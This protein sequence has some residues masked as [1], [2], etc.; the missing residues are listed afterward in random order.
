MRI[1]KINIIL[2][3]I[4]VFIIGL[5]GAY[6]GASML[7]SNNAEEKEVT[8]QNVE[9]MEKVEQAY[10]LIEQNYV[11][12][13]E[14]N[15]LIEGAIQGMLTTLDDPYSTYMDEEAMGNFNEQIESSFQGI[16][17]EVSMVEEKV[18]IIAPI[19]DSPAE[20]AGLKPN[21]QI[22]EVDG[23]DIKGLDLNEA[24]EKIRGEK[25]SKVTLS[26]LRG[27]EDFEVEL[28]RD[29]IPVETVYASTKEVDGKPT[30][31]IEITSFSEETYFDFEQE[32]SKLEKEGIEGLV[33][34]VRG[35]PGGLLDSVEDMLGEFVPKDIPFVQIEDQN[36]NKEKHFSELDNKKDYPVSI[37]IDE[38]SASASEI[39][40]VALKE[41]GYDVVGTNSFGKGTVQQAVPLGEE[42]MIK[43]TFF[44]WL[45][46]E[47]NWINEKGVKPTVEIKQPDYYYS[48]PIKVDKPFKLDESDDNIET[49]QII[50]DG[51]GYNLD[52]KDGYFDKDTVAALKEFQSEHSLSETGELDEETASALELQII[53]QIRDGKDDL[54]MDAALEALYK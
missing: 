23:E 24:V 19:K 42:G 47:G 29:D 45:S 40:A 52:R 6:F 14:G 30:G 54:Q 48:N 13:V 38:G 25:G 53:E 36:G 20:K 11:E 39:L 21:D 15:D 37:L 12:D 46:P 4:S 51:L 32:L 22:L 18:T 35:N 26:I 5:L 1:T 34:D 9:G 33:I 50:L 49:A 3:F 8:I 16:G 28:T 43:L 10:D 31:Y 27:E 41:V 2:L 7:Q 44:K 17:T